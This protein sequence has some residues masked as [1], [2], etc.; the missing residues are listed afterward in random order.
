MEGL[1]L[2][3]G[4]V[5]AETGNPE[6]LILYAWPKVGKTSALAQLSDNLIIDLEGGTKYMDAMAVQARTI[7]DLGKIA[8]AIREKNK[9]V[10]KNFYRRIT[11]DNCSDLEKIC[12]PYAATLYRKSDQKNATWNGDDVRD[13]PFGAGY[14]ALYKA[15]DRV[16]EMFK[17]LCDE[18][19][20]VGHEATKTKTI[21]GVETDVE[22][23][24]LAGS[25]GLELLKRAD[26]V[27]HMYR[28]G[29]EVHIEFSGD[30]NTMME[31][32]PQHLSGKDFVISTK[33]EEGNI[34]TYWDRIYK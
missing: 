25:Y 11:I 15:L 12:L 18:F 28:K 17:D 24:A 4:P 9:E 23:L 7:E 20:L 5:P 13:I 34:T 2:P 14:R 32:R 19:I 29:N 3:T 21:K 10:G 22:T 26:A 6:F 33:D 16:I 31:S 30:D 27:G 1:T 8:Q